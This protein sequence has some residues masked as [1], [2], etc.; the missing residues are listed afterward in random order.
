MTEK[1]KSALLEFLRGILAAL[2]A[3]VTA[4]LASACG[5]TRAV[6]TNRAEQTTTTIK[7]TTANPTSVSVPSTADVELSNS[8]F[9]E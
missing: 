9:N 6:V 3:F 8:K 2:V 1:M 4:L 5:T 7:I